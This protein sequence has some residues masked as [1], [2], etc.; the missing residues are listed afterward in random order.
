MR[1]QHPGEIVGQLAI[2]S[3]IVQTCRELEVPYPSHLLTFPLSHFPT[4]PL[5]HFP[6]AHALIFLDRVK[7]LLGLFRS[8]SCAS[9]RLVVR[10]C[11]SLHPRPGGPGPR[12]D[13]H[14]TK[15][16]A[17]TIGPAS[18]EHNNV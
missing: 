11:L 9:L 16:P 6:S 12:P 1:Q 8:F 7:F 5:S 14:A 13:R 3:R 10:P 2:M 4:F 17:K 18:P 15:R